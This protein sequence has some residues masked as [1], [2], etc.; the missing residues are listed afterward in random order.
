[1]FSNPF[2][3]FHNTVAEAK[4]EREHL[5]RLLTISTPRER[6]LVAAIAVLLVI[7]AVWLFFGS[8]TRSLALGGVLDEPGESPSD[9]QRSL[10]ALVVVEPHMAAQIETGTAAVLELVTSDLQVVTLEGE[11]ATIALE[12]SYSELLESAKPMSVYR[13]ELALDEG[14][15]GASGAMVRIVV[16]LG[17]QSPAELL[18]LGR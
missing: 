15:D 1:M 12:P 5:D 7:L 18:G 17:R 6:L 14:I 10:Q 16:D 13:I 11:I 9:Q 3:S 8:V 4:E 2:D